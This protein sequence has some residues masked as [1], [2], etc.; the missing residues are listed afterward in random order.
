LAM[1]VGRR[2]QGS[3]PIMRRPSPAARR[4]GLG[5]PRVG[6]REGGRRIYLVG[7]CLCLI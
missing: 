3:A 7:L 2:F 6:G 1:P 5:F 4:D